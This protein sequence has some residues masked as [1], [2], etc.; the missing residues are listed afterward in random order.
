MLGKITIQRFK[1]LE[2]LTLDLDRVNILVGSNNSGKSSILQAIQFAVSVGQ[3]ASLQSNV[4]WKDEKLSTSLSPQQLI[5]APLRDVYALAYGGKLVE[6]K[7]QA[8]IISFE[9]NQEK[10]NVLVTVR[11][12][13]NR[14]LSITVEGKELGERLQIIE[15]P[16]SIYVPGLAGIP[17]VEE[18]KTPG[19][20]R[21]AAA[22]GD[23]NKVFRNV[24]YL[25][26]NESE[27]WKQFISDFNYLFPDL[28]VIVEF[29]PERDDYINCQIQ[30]NDENSLPIDL[31]GTGVL[32][33]IQIIS[34]INIYK[35]QILLL[36]EPD[37]HLHPNNQRKLAKMLIKLTEERDLQI[38][39]TTHSRHLLD[40]LREKTKIYWLKN[41]TI[42]NEKD[43][44]T[45]QLL[46]DI[47][48]LDKDELLL[49]TE[50]IKCVLL[51]ED[52]DTKPIETL[53]EASG[54]RM[55]EV[56]IWSY[57]GCTKV[58][59]ALVLAA[60]IRKHS[61][62]TKILLHRDRDYLTDD[63]ANDFREKI[64]RANI[65][66]FLTT[67]TD[68][69]SHF[70]NL[71]HIQSLY[72]QLTTDRIQELI[73]NSTAEKSEKSKEK[74]INSR[75]DIELQQSRQKGNGRINNGQIA[76]N[77]YQMYDQ[78]C[79]RYRY[80]K[81]VLKTL[82][83]KLQQEVGGNIDLFCVTDSLKIAELEELALLIWSQRKDTS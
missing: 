37:S 2:N 32:Q 16:Y 51:T 62:Q 63:E 21:K 77:C 27:Q 41:G 64:E 13:R 18:C 38:I 23:A 61:S 55:D 65:L 31:A 35:P 30:A 53:L 50:N 73:S 83:S 42:I 76:S 74:F 59:T 26:H 70:I 45:V 20:V 72:P 68:A 4:N 10:Q 67:G 54:F 56:D 79:E 15:T 8:I 81:S 7:D 66:C 48:A 6:N 5:Y 43:F 22:R 12:G 57:K 52:E 69:E 17:D 36:D 75:T 28:K 60:F 9:E 40:A 1:N 25:L 71:G 47:G 78:D 44:D 34:Y 46:L 80:G 33:A 39:V 19:I 82:K 58:E 29:N 11:K 14:N 3:T 49:N 24:L